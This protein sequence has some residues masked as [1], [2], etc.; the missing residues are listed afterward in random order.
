MHRRTRSLGATVGAL[1]MALVATACSSAGADAPD[2]GG[3]DVEVTAWTYWDGTNA[4]TFDA[5]VQE[6]DDATDGVA[7]TTATIPNAD[8]LTKL[9]AAAT[10]DTLPTIAIG[11]LVWVPQIAQLGSLADLT[12]LLPA[13][14]IADINPAL[15]SFGSID[16]Q[17]VSVPVSANNLAFMYNTTLYEEAGLDP[18]APP[19]TWDEVLSTG[20]TILEKTGKPGYELFTHAGDNGEGLTWNFQVNLWQAGGDFLTEDN[21]A[22]AFNTEAGTQALQYWVDLIGA[23]VS[24]YT[25]WGEFEKGSAAAAQEGSWMVGIW[26]PDPPF[27]FATATVPMPSDGVAATNLGG[28]QAMVFGTDDDAAQAA[29]D[30]LAWF[31]EPEQV[32]AWSET[33]GMLPVT[34]SV[35]TGEDYLGWVD[36]TQP[37]LRPYV[38]QMADAHA[39]PNTPLYPAIS[40]AFAQ[41]IEK[42]LAGEVGVDQALSDAEAAVNAVIAEG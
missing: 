23:G 35:A 37:L 15:V 31:L 26:A 27:D 36:E 30:F 22:A 11:D 9:R 6:Y 38:E 10:S 1:S 7:I 39:R 16:G 34:D 29:A 33:T 32:T 17:Q 24:P 14:T 28:E 25:A 3:D 2:T 12:E 4:D 18:A 13:E 42:A 19:T 5:M 41:E 8:F 21:S 20:A 40:F